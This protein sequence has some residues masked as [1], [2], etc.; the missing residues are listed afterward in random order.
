[1]FKYLA[2]FLI[3]GLGFDSA[4]QSSMNNALKMRISDRTLPSQFTIL[5][6]GNIQ[7]LKSNTGGLNYKFNY[8]GGD[9]ASIT[10]DLNSL[11]KLIE[12]K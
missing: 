8:S 4:A 1:M 5:V 9:I 10:S 12:N 11:S 7:K 3:L 6:K 2:F